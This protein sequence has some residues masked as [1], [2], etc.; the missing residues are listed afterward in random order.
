MA[1]ARRRAVCASETS[2]GTEYFLTIWQRWAAGLLP[3]NATLLCFVVFVLGIHI[4]GVVWEYLG[5]FKIILQASGCPFNNPFL[6]SYIEG[7]EGIGLDF[8]SWREFGL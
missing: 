4:F 6:T 8:L 3:E 2:G 5:I 7:T 1:V